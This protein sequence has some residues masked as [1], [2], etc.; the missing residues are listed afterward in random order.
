MRNVVRE[1]VRA[2]ESF[3]FANRDISQDGDVA[4]DAHYVRSFNAIDNAHLEKFAET[5]RRACRQ[6][7]L[8][9]RAYPYRISRAGLIRLSPRR[10][11]D[12]LRDRHEASSRLVGG[13]YERS[14]T[15]HRMQRA[16]LATTRNDELA[17]NDSRSAERPHRSLTR[18]RQEGL[19]RTRSCVTKRTVRAVSR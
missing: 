3:R 10:V 17:I 9:T 4:S 19:E 18:R 8:R 16:R 13:D 15:G 2:I 5:L 12:L 11:E 6:T 14:R 7:R 1:R